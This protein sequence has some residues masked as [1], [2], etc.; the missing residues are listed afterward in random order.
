MR[1]EI[2]A[3]KI[4]RSRL[5]A[6]NEISILKSISHEN[7]VQFEEEFYENGLYLIVMEYCEGGDLKSVIK[8]QK[9]KLKTPFLEETVVIWFHQLISGINYLHNNHIIHRD[10]KPANIFL[11][12]FNKLK[13]GDFGIAKSLTNSAGKSWLINHYLI[14][15]QNLFSSD[16]S[17]KAPETYEGRSILFKE[18]IWSLGCTLYDICTLK[19]AFDSKEDVIRGTYEPIPCDVHPQV[20]PFVPLMLKYNP[21]ERLSVDQMQNSL[22]LRGAGKLIKK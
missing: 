21:I 19:F 6:Q 2:F 15:F 14:S 17:Y 13:I 1:E 22:F 9:T 7:I 11:K 8:H 5:T 10:I 4:Q 18:D 12:S 3:M 20:S 16:F